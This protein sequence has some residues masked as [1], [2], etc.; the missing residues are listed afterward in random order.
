[1]EMFQAGGTVTMDRIM[2]DIGNKTKIKPGDK[3]I[4][5]GRVKNLK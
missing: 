2:F 5:L 4:L 3:V 1:M